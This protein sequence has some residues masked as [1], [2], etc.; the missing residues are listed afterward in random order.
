MT[1]LDHG[2]DTVSSSGDSEHQI[3]RL[4]WARIISISIFWFALNFHW[5]AIGTIILPSQVF[6]LVGALHQGA[7]LATILVPGAFVALL[8]NPL[9]G[10]ASDRTRGRLARWGR[11]R[12]YIFIGT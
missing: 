12:P 7:A 1:V 8:T 9:W 4:H 11:R 10:M 5:A 3:P 2:D 6:K